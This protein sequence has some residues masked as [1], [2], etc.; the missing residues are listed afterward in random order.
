[1]LALAATN[2]DAGSDQ[3]WRQTVSLPPSFPK[4]SSRSFQEF[5]W[6]SWTTRCTLS[7]GFFQTLPNQRSEFV[8]DEENL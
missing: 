7:A 2:V 6:G 3:R 8:A 1:M 4:F 5:T